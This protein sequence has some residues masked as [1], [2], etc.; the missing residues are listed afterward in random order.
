[1]SCTA[2]TS[3]ASSLLQPFVVLQNLHGRGIGHGQFCVHGACD[4]KGCR[5]GGVI[6][7]TQECCKYLEQSILDVLPLRDA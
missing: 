1:V 2:P 5:D 6:R 3:A 7:Y 4:V